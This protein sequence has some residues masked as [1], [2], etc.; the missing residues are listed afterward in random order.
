MHTIGHEQEVGSSLSVESAVPRDDAD[1]LAGEEQVETA[2]VVEDTEDDLRGVDPVVRRRI[3]DWAKRLIDLSRRNRLL[4]YRPTKRTTLRLVAPDAIEI[5]ETLLAEGSWRF[6][7]PPDED[8]GGPVGS[9]SEALSLKSPRPRELVTHH[10]DRKELVRSLEVISRRA[11]AEFQDRG[12]HVLQLGWGMVRWQDDRSNEPVRSPLLLIPTILS[13]VSIK[14]PWTLRPAD[15]DPFLN[16][17][18]RVKLHSDFGLQLPEVTDFADMRLADLADSIAKELPSGWEVESEAVLGIFGFAKEAMYRDLVDHIALVAADAQVQTLAHGEP[19]GEMRETLGISVPS[20]TELD[21]VQDPATSYSVLDADSSQRESIAAAIAGLSFVMHGPPGTGKSQ[22]IANI[23]AEFI[24][25]G[26]SVLFVSEKIAAL[27]VVAN[28]LAEAGLKDM[29]LELHSHK[30]SRKE[31]A[32]ELARVLDEDVVPHAQM[33]TAELDLLR[34]SRKHLNDY[35]AALHNRREPLGRSVRAVLSELAA[36]ES[37]R[38]LPS[39]DVDASKATPDDLLQVEAVI[40]RLSASWAPQDP[41]ATFTWHHAALERYTAADRVRIAD[42]LAAA[43]EAVSRVS[44]VEGEILSVLGLESPTSEQQ[45]DSIAHVGVLLADHPDVPRSWLTDPDLREHIRQTERWTAHSIERQTVLE[46]LLSVYG[47]NWTHL[48]PQQASLVAS[49]ADELAGSLGVDDLDTVEGI[50]RLTALRQ[51]AESLERIGS[52]ASGVYRQTAERLGL[53]PRLTRI[54]DVGRVAEVCQL[55]QSGLRPPTAWLSR[56]R[57]EEARSFLDERRGLYIGYQQAFDRLNAEYDLTAFESVKLE[58]LIARLEARHGK[59]WSLLR[60]SH[61]ADRRLLRSLRRDRELPARPIEDLRAIA[62]LR[63]RRHS[64]DQIGNDERRILGPLAAGVATNLLEAETILAVAERLAEVGDLVADWDTFADATTSG[65]PYSPETERLGVRLDRLYTGIEQAAIELASGSEERLDAWRAASPEEVVNATVAITDRAASLQALIGGLDQWRTVPIQTMRTAIGDLQRRG[66]VASEDDR[67]QFEASELRRLFGDRFSEWETDWE[68]IKADLHWARQ[69]RAAYKGKP[70]PNTLADAIQAGVG[71]QLPFGGYEQTRTTLRGAAEAVAALFESDHRSQVQLALLAEPAQASRYIEKLAATAEEISVWVQHRSAVKGA[72]EAGWSDFVARASKVA[73]AEE[74]VPAARRAW[75]ESWVDS[76]IDQDETLRPFA[77]AE[78][79]RLSRT[80]G[81]LDE[82]AISK[83]RERLLA[84]Y[85]EGKPHGFA[86]QGGEEA[87]VRRE[88][89][90]KKRHIPVRKL[91]SQI[92]RLLPR[93]KPGLMMSPLSVSHFLPAEARFDIVIFDEASQVPP[94]DAINCVYRGA[95]L[96]VAGDEHQ[97]P[98]TD[99]FNVAAESEEV[100]DAEAQVDDFESVLDVCR[101]SGF[102]VKALRWHYRSRH[103]ELIAFSNHHIY[104]NSLVTFPAP[105]ERLPEMGVHFIHV[106]EGVFDRGRSSKNAVEAARV[107]DVVVHLVR[108]ERRDSI[109]VVAF[110]VAQQEAILDELERRKRLEPDLESLIDGDRLSGLFVKNLET[111]QGDERDMIVFSVGYGRDASGRFLMNFGPLNR[112]GGRRRLN[113]AVTRARERV[114]VVSSV[115]GIDFGSADASGTV[116]SEGPRLLQAYLDYAER[117]PEALAGHLAESGGDFDS[118]FEREVA[119]VIRGMGYEVVPQVGTSGYRIDIG[120]RSPSAPGRF[121]VGVECDGAMYHSAKTARDRDRLRQS[122]LEGLG[123]R[124]HRVWSQD[125]FRHR[126]SEVERLREA[127]EGAERDLVAKLA[128]PRSS[129]RSEA[130]LSVTAPSPSAR[131][132]V[133]RAPAE[134]SVAKDALP[135]VQPYSVAQVAKY[136][137]WAD[138]ND[139]SMRGEHARRIAA[140]VA[141]EGPLHRDYIATRLA[142]AFGLARTGARMQDAVEAAIKQAQADGAIEARGPFVW[143]KGPASLKVRLP[144]AGAP[145]TQRGI[146]EVPPE[147]VDVALLR[148]VEAAMSIDEDLL[149]T[150]VAR[151]LG[152]ERTGGRIGELLRHRI[153]ANLANGNLSREGG[154]LVLKAELPRLERAKR[155]AEPGPSGGRFY[156][157]GERLRHP[158]YG[159]GVVRAFDGKHVTVAFGDVVKEFSA[160]Q[161]PFERIS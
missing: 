59:W 129:P 119:S 52:E 40:G 19:M 72:Q 21:E 124:I 34:S 86:V 137:R 30:A 93:I 148:T 48:D 60:P 35:V 138:F 12:T 101:A 22:T 161:A 113:V 120:I 13:R 87:V 73:S 92:P 106:P 147:E 104:G 84:R 85:A 155:V 158:R 102:P 68:S 139:W 71:A 10:A 141:A 157:R 4:Y 88:A 23:I 109:G 17:A 127:I 42:T 47:G 39:P 114:I 89:A 134:G 94:E 38:G 98:P 27:E 83:A 132:R 140:L 125:W 63:N 51:A 80:F 20:G 118:E 56:P 159:E 75:L 136:P 110:S 103:D 6:Y 28:R 133:M 62:D 24:G 160:E 58:P 152:Y 41:T 11:N 90:K 115:R 149:V 117:G 43:K 99:F 44:H 29:V 7:E 65:T 1:D 25:H 54:E 154:S 67:I 126:S 95:Q 116:K 50:Q 32:V 45:R 82:A 37:V 105:V 3:Q 15:D 128:R 2:A 122:V 78:H 111:V 130:S 16:P 9:V 69:L 5:A 112:Q 151:L 14:E 18:L 33:S 156:R 74:L 46:P 150:Q 64:I 76:A 77:R 96:I 135:W 31:V 97:L 79:E 61:R 8:A 81:E 143:P 49:V 108:E 142:R 55:S 131:D 70:V 100:E 36:M 57:R 144:V 153:A 26:R 66:A 53:H 107:V 123:W 121:V 91:I 146:E 145:D